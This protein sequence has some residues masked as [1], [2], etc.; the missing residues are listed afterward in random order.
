[1]SVYFSGMI[2][3]L[4]T[5]ELIRQLMAIERRPITLMKQKISRIE[6][7]QSAWRDV[8][9]RL[10]N[11]ESK[12]KELLNEDLFAAMK[13]TSS[14][15]GVA[16]ASVRAG[17][18]PATYRIEVQ[19]LAQAYVGAGNKI[20]LST[21]VAAQGTLIVKAGDQESEVTIEAGASLHDAAKAINEQARGVRASVVNVDGQ[22]ARLVLES[23]TPGE[24]YIVEVQGDSGLL[25]DL[26]LDEWQDEKGQTIQG[27][28]TIQ[29]AQ[30]AVFTVNGLEIERGTNEISDAIQGITFTLLA[31]GE[32]TITVGQDLDGIIAKIKAVV[33]QYNSFYTFSQEKLAKDAV[34]QGDS[35]LIQLVSRVRLALTEPIGQRSD[36]A[37]GGLNQL[38]LLGI[39]TT[40][41]GTLTLDETVLREKLAEDPLAVQR[42][43][44]AKEDGGI[45]GVAQRAVDLIQQYTRSSGLISSR[46]SMYRNMIDDINEQIDSLELRM[47]RREETMRAQFIR[48]EQM[49]ATLNA[50][51]TALAGQL[52]QISAISGGGGRGAG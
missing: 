9:T 50:Q 24:Q 44:T 29:A 10:S 36:W 17:A 39:T 4:D 6:E 42:L 38:A 26:G 34:L 46:Q 2:S 30:N 25:A 23:L 20:D 14:A 31:T 27:L 12:L 51:A 11:L 5:D 22:H 8:N 47:Q 1:M 37:T 13:A 28:Q 16:K 48:M 19:Q 43:F 18:P 35:A 15:E 32:T 49:L 3:G 21:T 40:R 41:E 52:A 33:D 45:A 7:Q